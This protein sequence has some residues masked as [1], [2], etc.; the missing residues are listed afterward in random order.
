MMNGN[1]YATTIN[2]TVYNVYNGFAYPPP[3]KDHRW[4]VV[5]LVFGAICFPKIVLPGIVVGVL[6]FAAY[7]AF[8]H[9]ARQEAA[10]RAQQEE[11]RRRC[12][13]ENRLVQEGDPAGTLGLNYTPPEVRS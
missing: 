1:Q 12:E 11:L 13:L 10:R 2:N 6:I 8:L 4:K 3:G 7:R 5:L 9:Y